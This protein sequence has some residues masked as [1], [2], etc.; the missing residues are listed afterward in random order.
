M[1]GPSDADSKLIKFM[2]PAAASKAAAAALEEGRG[3]VELALGSDPIKV[4]RAASVG[5]ANRRT[6]INAIKIVLD[7]SFIGSLSFSLPT[8]LFP[9]SERGI[10]A[11]KLSLTG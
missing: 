1:M 6:L 3:S 7:K 2:R 8:L 10:K 4:T 11:S 9:I 5:L